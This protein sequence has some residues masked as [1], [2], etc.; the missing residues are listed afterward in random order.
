LRA[1]TP[2]QQAASKRDLVSYAGDIASIS[3]GIL[4]LG[5]IS[6]EERE[7]IERIAAELEQTHKTAAKSVIDTA[8]ED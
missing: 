8:S 6:R 1:L 5:K 3:G 7:V 2:E 4:G